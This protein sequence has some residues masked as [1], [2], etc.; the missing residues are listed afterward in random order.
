MSLTYELS[1]E[2]VRILRPYEVIEPPLG[3][4]ELDANE[5]F[6]VE[7]GWAKE[8]VLKAATLVDPRRYP[9]P[10]GREAVEALS[11]F[12]SVEA[13]AIAVNN[14]SDE[15]VDLLFK[16]FVNPGEEVVIIEPTFEIYSLI[17]KVAGARVKE[18]LVKKEDFSLNV[19]KVLEALS[20]K[21][22]LVFL[23]SPN[24]PTGVQYSLKEVREVAETFKGIVVVDEAYA[25]FSEL[26][27]LKFALEL[28]NLLVSRS[29]SK[30]AG[31]AGLRIGYAVAHPSIIEMLRKVDLPFRV[32]AVA[33]KAASLVL[34]KWSVVEGFIR[35]VKE[36]REKLF[37]ELSSLKGLKTYPSKANFILT[38]VVKEGLTS[39]QVRDFLMKMGI[40]VRDRGHLPL[41]ENCLRITV[42]TSEANAKLVDALRKVME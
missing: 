33:Q 2:N 35:K 15:F 5:N 16:A 24:N 21:V 1:R 7:E 25:D 28:E 31:M 4:I 11:R 19:E 27:V 29:F 3:V 34:E 20:S 40:M 8:T 9:P 6:L 13:E 38:R 30:V 23:C 32:N 22:K 17:A 18:A 10:Y 14:G 37:N 26:S 41:L 36:E 12:L 42:G 39:T